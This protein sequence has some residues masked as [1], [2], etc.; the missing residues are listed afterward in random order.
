M[1]EK[2]KGNLTAAEQNFIGNCLYELRMAYVEVTTAITR[3]P[4]PT[5]EAPGKK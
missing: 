4:Q 5:T 3:A 2:T 1:A